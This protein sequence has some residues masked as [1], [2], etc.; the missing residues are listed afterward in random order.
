MPYTGDGRW[1][2]VSAHQGG[3]A[4]NA[5]RRPRFWPI[6]LVA[7]PA[8]ISSAILLGAWSP[9][10]AAP[11]TMAQ[12]HQVIACTPT[13]STINQTVTNVHIVTVTKPPVVHT[14]TQVQ[15]QTA[16]A[17]IGVP[18]TVISTVTP[19]PVT[20]TQVVT[21][22][23]TET[24]T[25]TVTAPPA[26]GSFLA[27]PMKRAPQAVRPVQAVQPRQDC[28]VVFVTNTFTDNVTSTSSVTST[29]HVTNTANVTN[30][31]LVTT[32]NTLDVTNTKTA[33]VEKKTSFSHDARIAVGVGGVAVSGVAGFVFL[34][35]RRRGDYTL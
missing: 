26:A 2:A 17:T 33:L 27:R 35:L 4:V 3:S 23:V 16:T 14:Q 31:N 5:R 32:V 11:V 13:T 25:E 9:A 15:T 24:H 1:P 29:N 8:A 19:P 20:Q 12:P 34:R 6:V 22:T 7:T 10:S 30:T 28:P 21:Q 18:T